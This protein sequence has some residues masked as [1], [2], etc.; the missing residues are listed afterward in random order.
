MTSPQKPRFIT[1]LVEEH[2][3]LPEGCCMRFKVVADPRAVRRV[4]YAAEG[5]TPRP[6]DG[7]ASDEVWLVES[8]AADDGPRTAWGVPVEDSGAGTCTLIYG[9]ARGLRLRREAGDDPIAEPYLLLA[10]DA[11]VEWGQ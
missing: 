1:V 6:G 10:H 4:R 11:V 9:G 5:P 2:E 7:G 8:P 3:E